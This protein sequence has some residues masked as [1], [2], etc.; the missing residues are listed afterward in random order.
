MIVRTRFEAID[1]YLTK[2]LRG[3]RHMFLVIIVDTV[4]LPSN[5]FNTKENQTNLN[6][7]IEQITWFMFDLIDYSC[8][9]MGARWRGATGR[10]FITPA[11]DQNACNVYDQQLQRSK[12]ESMRQERLLPDY[13]MVLNLADLTFCLINFMLCQSLLSLK[14]LVKKHQTLSTLPFSVIQVSMVPYFYYEQKLGLLRAP[15]VV[16]LML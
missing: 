5:E 16:L 10:R 13:N 3:L 8:K 4:V 2:M 9:L 6:H 7:I 14:H 12:R 15:V 11:L 1:R